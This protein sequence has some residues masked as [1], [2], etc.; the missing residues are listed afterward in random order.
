M[1]IASY[2]H[3]IYYVSNIV[4]SKR[5]ALTLKE[6]VLQNHDEW[7]KLFPSKTVPQTPSRELISGVEL[8]EK[9][10]K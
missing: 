2:E 7:Q 3:N 4:A 9:K 6:I 10:E 5:S 8:Q 1:A